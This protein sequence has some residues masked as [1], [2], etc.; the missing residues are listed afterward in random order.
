MPKY[1]PFLKLKQ[2]ELQSLSELKFSIQEKIRPFFDVPRTSKNQSA[3]EIYERLDLGIGQLQKLIKQRGMFEFYVD[4]F[5]L[6]DSILLKGLGQYAYILS[7]FA[8]F[9]AIPVVALD[10]IDAHNIES[11]RVLW[12]HVGL[13]QT[14]MTA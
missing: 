11:P 4:S 2:N 3:A 8:E 12:R 5:D 6:D 13:S 7:R 9:R 10:R 14:D 1:I